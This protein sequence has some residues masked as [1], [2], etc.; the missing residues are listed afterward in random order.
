MANKYIFPFSRLC[1]LNSFL[2]SI[3]KVNL[4][5]TS[6]LQNVAKFRIYRWDPEKEE[7]PKMQVKTCKYQVLKRNATKL[8]TSLSQKS[9]KIEQ[10][11]EF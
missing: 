1:K 6:S 9:L 5:T 4:S 11:I 8:R 7:K 3:S 10:Q 2:G